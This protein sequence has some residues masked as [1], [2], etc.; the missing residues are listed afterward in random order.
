MS[1]RLTPI[2]VRA[3]QRS[4]EWHIARLGNVT[5][6]RAEDT[7]DYNKVTA[8]DLDKALSVYEANEIDPDYIEE[9][10]TEYP[11][12]FCI[13]AGIELKESAKRKAYRE[14]I[15][16]ERITRLHGDTD[17]Y[18]NDAMK[19]GI[20]NEEGAK[21]LYRRESGNVIREAPLMLHPHL[22]CGASADGI[23]IDTQTG[24]IGNAEVKCLTS[25]NHL[26]RII[27]DAKMP[28]DYRAQVQMQIWIY[29][30][31]WS[32]FIGYDSRVGEGLDYFSEHIER[33]DFYIDNVLEP[34]IRQ[35]LAECDADER[36]FYAIRKSR[37]ERLKTK[38]DK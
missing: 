29:G 20:W 24:E 2:I 33:D 1:E 32:K 5:A 11:T 4:D 34:M 13:N 10:M 37:L 36:L 27:R 19:W 30:V 35:F 23:V 16:A 26:Y 7:M 8:V 6:S 12:A 3:P 14:T 31:D 25:H 17:P 28:E 18:V 15:V 9:M 21:N 38:E 22:M